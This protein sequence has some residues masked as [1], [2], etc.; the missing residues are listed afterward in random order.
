MILLLN[1][2]ESAEDLLKLS[3]EEILVRWV[4]YQ[5][6][7]SDFKGELIK[8][9]SNDIKDSIVYTYLLKQIT[10]PE[11]HPKPNLDPLKVT[12]TKKRKVSLF[13]ISIYF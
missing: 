9:L 1:D 3:Q 10:P 7:K 4:N 5:L 6:K 11:H 13:F 12:L 8:D 2:G